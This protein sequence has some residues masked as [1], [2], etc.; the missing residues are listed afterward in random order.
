MPFTVD[1]F[2]IDLQQIYGKFEVHGKFAATQF[3]VD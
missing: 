2:V 3:A 1:K